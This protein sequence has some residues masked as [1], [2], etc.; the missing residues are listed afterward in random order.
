MNLVETV[1]T[2]QLYQILKLVCQDGTVKKKKKKKKIEQYRRWQFVGWEVRREAERI[3][4]QTSNH[5]SRKEGSR[6]Q[7]KNENKRP[8][9]SISHFP[10][11]PFERQ[12][13]ETEKTDKHRHDIDG[14]G[15]DAILAQNFQDGGNKIAEDR[16][17][18]KSLGKWEAALT[19]VPENA[20]LHEQKAQGPLN[21]NILGRGL[22]ILF[23]PTSEFSLFSV[24]E[25]K[26]NLK[27]TKMAWI[28]LGRARLNFGEPDNA[29]ESFDRVLT[30]K[31][32]RHLHL[33][34]LSAS[35]NH[36][37]GGDKPKAREALERLEKKT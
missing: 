25:E 22:S 16:K 30:L 28:T 9:A 21:W 34:G 11:L 33:F 20:V 15:D 29:I 31:R 24:F 23:H 12:D 17:Y 7:R 35:Q 5:R 3:E 19:L 18:R 1:E 6:Q 26:Y 27:G 14:D 36:F 8:L 37:T 32:Q 13:Y 2:V 10:N 4:T